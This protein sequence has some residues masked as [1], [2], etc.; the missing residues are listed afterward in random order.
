[1]HQPLAGD[2]PDLIGLERAQRAP[3]RAETLDVVEV[4]GYVQWDALVPP[5]SVELFGQRLT[6]SIPVGS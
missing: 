4:A 2:V 6:V 3:A 1:V 5:L